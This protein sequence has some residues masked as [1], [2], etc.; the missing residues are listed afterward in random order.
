MYA[1]AT[2]ATEPFEIHAELCPLITISSAPTFAVTL[3]T[4]CRPFAPSSCRYRIA[5][6]EPRSGC[7]FIQQPTLPAHISTSSGLP[8]ECAIISG[9]VAAPIDTAR[10]ESPQPSSSPISDSIRTAVSGGNCAI[11]CGSRPSFALS[12]IAAQYGEP[13]AITSSGVMRSSSRP[14][15]RST[16]RAKRCT[17]C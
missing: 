1:S 11:S 12:T 7:V 17:V 4:G 8:T 5:A 2:C 14:I 3:P 9:I 13:G 15:G 16:S 10:P 6:S